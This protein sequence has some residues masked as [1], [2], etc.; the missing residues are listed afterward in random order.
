[1][2]GEIALKSCPSRIIAGQKSPR[3]RENGWIII[4]W[5][6]VA[7]TLSMRWR[8]TWLS[9]TVTLSE[10]RRLERVTLH[11]HCHLPDF[12]CRILALLSLGTLENFQ[13]QVILAHSVSFENCGWKGHI[14]FGYDYLCAVILVGFPWHTFSFVIFFWDYVYVWEC[15]CV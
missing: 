7:L 12:I 1:M 10:T 14:N 8:E 9:F 2:I 15:V 6:C 3:Q 4:L 5:N 13:R 11:S